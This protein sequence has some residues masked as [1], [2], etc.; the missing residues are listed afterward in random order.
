MQTTPN[1]AD[2]TSDK[3]QG[4]VWSGCGCP[5]S[6]KREDQM[7]TAYLLGVTTAAALIIAGAVGWITSPT[8]ARVAS[9]IGA[10]ID[11][12]QLTLSAQNLPT[13]KYEDFSVVFN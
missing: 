9:P 12:L 11:T 8:N 6:F 10:Q 13:Q 2:M 7:R 4:G 1:W 5:S 3:Y